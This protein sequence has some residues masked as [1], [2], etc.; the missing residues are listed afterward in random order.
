MLDYY[1][2][3]NPCSILEMIYPPMKVC[4]DESVTACEKYEGCDPNDEWI[5]QNYEYLASIPIAEPSGSIYQSFFT[6]FDNYV[7]SY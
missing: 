6:I 3:D 1:A 2:A 5:K 7:M 4:E